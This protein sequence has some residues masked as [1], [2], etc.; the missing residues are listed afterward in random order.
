MS[1][2]YLSGELSAYLENNGMAHT[3]GKPYHPQTQ[4]KIERWHRSLHEKPDSAESL[5]F[6][7]RASGTA[8]AVCELL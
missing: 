3:R 4:G 1:P 6:T 2:C 8:T 5:L 7:G